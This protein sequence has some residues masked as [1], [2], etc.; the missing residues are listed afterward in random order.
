MSESAVCKVLKTSGF[1][2]QKLVTYALQRDGL[3]RDQFSTDVS[4]YEPNSLV[5]LDETGTDS[6]DA[7]RTY[8]YS[9]RGK[10]L[11]AQ[12]LLVRGE[13]VS[14][15]AAMSMNGIIGL[16]IVRGGVNADHVYDFVCTSYFITS[17]LTM[18]LMTTV[19][20]SWTT[21]PFTMYLKLKEWSMMLE[22]SHTSLVPRLSLFFFQLYII[23][24]ESL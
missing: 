18:A 16:K 17:C 10:P 4:L 3:L 13:H 14:A 9:I 21:V 11:Q 8:G 7:V 12:K 1:T 24:F 23:M 6:R 20:L 22:L 19:Y 15:I 2:R 5:F